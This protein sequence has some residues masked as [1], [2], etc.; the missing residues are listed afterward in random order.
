MKYKDVFEGMVAEVNKTS[1]DTNF[2]ATAKIK[3]GKSDERNKNNRIYP[4]EVASAAIETF[5]K[6]AGK[7]AGVVGNLDH[8]IGASGTLLA[9]ASHL[10]SKVWK[11]REK[12]WWAE[13]K[14]FDT[15]KGRD[16][17]TILKS[18]TTIGA[19]L[20]GAGEIDKSG[21]VLPG[22]EFR[23]IDFVS[24]PSFGASASV[25]QSSV[26]ESYVAENED[27]FD[28]ENLEKFTKAM[29]GLNDETIKLIQE[30]LANSEGIVMTKEKIEGL[31]LWLKCSKNNKNIAPFHEWFLDQQRLFGKE[32]PN[33]QEELNSSL[34][35]QANARAE[36]RIAN[37]PQHANLMFSNKKQ[38][39]D[40]QRKIDEA[41]KGSRYDTKTISRLFAEACLAGYKGSRADWITEF[42]F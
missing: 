4:D 6:E 8:P 22:L 11:D 2:L 37:S 16:L 35:R 33:F 26:F 29:A 24:A 13:V 21:K 28:E 32:N 23:A 25:D 10:V 14:V 20:R 12:L 27:Q 7:N 39:E 41:L 40:R 42:G 1:K 36:K 30:K 18:G 5:N 34:R 19:S 38:I 9:N 31:V 17:M 3:W 15:S